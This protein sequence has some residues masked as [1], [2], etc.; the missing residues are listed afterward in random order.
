MED[1]MHAW[2][3]GLMRMDEKVIKQNHKM[4]TVKSGY[5]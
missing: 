1:C 5:L 4:F 2:V 3:D